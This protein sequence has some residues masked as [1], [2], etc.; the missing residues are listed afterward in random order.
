MK[1][2]ETVAIIINN[3]EDEQTLLET[4]RITDTVY[5]GLSTNKFFLEYMVEMLL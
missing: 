2:Y 1:A 3:L 4:D 5:Y